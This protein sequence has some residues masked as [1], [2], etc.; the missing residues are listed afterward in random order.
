MCGKRR[1]EEDK[2]ELQ[3]IRVIGID[4]EGQERHIK[5]HSDP[6]ERCDRPKMCTRID[7]AHADGGRGEERVRSKDDHGADQAGQ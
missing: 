4:E 1:D 7:A 3:R 5:R 2:H 6:R